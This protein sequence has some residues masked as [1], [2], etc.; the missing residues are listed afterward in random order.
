[1]HGDSEK[2]LHTTSVVRQNDALTAYLVATGAISLISLIAYFESYAS[3]T[4]VRPGSDTPKQKYINDS[5]SSTDVQKAI[6][7]SQSKNL[8]MRRAVRSTVV[9]CWQNDIRVTA[10]DV[11][12]LREN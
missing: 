12:F 6:V 7:A 9:L 5:D 2:T 1:M 3:M 8:L 4:S 10:L 11:L